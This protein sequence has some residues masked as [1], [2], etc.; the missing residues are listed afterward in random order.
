MQDKINEL[1]AKIKMTQDKINELIAEI[2][3]IEPDT[4]TDRPKW[5][6]NQR[7]LC[8]NGQDAE[9]RSF[10]SEHDTV[11]ELKTFLESFDDDDLI[12]IEQDSDWGEVFYISAYQ[13]TMYNDDE[14]INWLQS[15]LRIV[16]VIQLTDEEMAV[17]KEQLK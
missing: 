2:K 10:R 4:D 9:C 15:I 13:K 6:W 17:L 12:G 5:K 11:G 8:S 16:K 3:A 14:Y 1:I 7:V